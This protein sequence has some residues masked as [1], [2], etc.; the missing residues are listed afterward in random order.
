MAG[1]TAIP[2]PKN[3]DGILGQHGWSV[4]E[5]VTEAAANED[6]EQRRVKD[7]ISN[8]VFLYSGPYPLR[9]S[10]FIK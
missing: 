5:D 3:A 6:A 4:E 8:L 10:H 2:D 7:K 1:H 9:A